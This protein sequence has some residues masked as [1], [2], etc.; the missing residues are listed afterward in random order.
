MR[1]SRPSLRLLAAL[2]LA[3]PTVACTVVE[4]RQNV[5]EYVDDSTITNTI[6]ARYIDDP[7]VHFGD[8]GVTTMNGVVHLS[9]RVN[10]W[11]ERSRAGQIAA[12][13]RGVKRVDNTIIVRN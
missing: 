9:G 4:G 2:A 6:R 3:V 12:G 11:P 5:A 7:G 10:S 13:V 1:V 8:V